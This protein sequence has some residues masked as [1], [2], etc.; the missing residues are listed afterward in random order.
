MVPAVSRASKKYGFWRSVERLLSRP[1][2]RMAEVNVGKIAALTKSGD[3]V[4]VPGKVLG[5]GDIEHS[6]TV[7]ALSFSST[8]LSKLR[9]AGCIVMGIDEL[10]KTEP[11][12]SGVK[13]I[14]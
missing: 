3:K 11:R 14:V 1:R 9:A 6:V 10:A 12:G 5:K 13:V 7:A 4:V 8:A 2:S